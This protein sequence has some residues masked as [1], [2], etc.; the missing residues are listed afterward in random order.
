MAMSNAERQ[1]RYRKSRGT[2]GDNGQRQL[3]VWVTTTAALSLNHLAKRYGVTKREM[4]ERLI[5]EED[6]RV[7][8]GM[9]EEEIDRYVTE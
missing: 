3:N 6:A 7:T 1:K 9:S 5:A 4:L 2:A 8:H